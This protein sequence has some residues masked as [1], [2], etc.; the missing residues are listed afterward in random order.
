MASEFFEVLFF[1]YT[2]EY[3]VCWAWL[4]FFSAGRHFE[5]SIRPLPAIPPK[6]RKAEWKSN[7]FI[8]VFS[9]AAYHIVLN[10]SYNNI[11]MARFYLWKKSSSEMLIN[12]RVVFTFT[13]QRWSRTIFSSE[14]Q[15][16]FPHGFGSLFLLFNNTS[17][18][19]LFLST[20]LQEVLQLQHI[21]RCVMWGRNSKKLVLEI[22]VE[23][24]VSL[25]VGTG[26]SWEA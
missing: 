23:I 9:L 22:D 4:L 21:Q 18:T 7:F 12:P 14:H 19:S 13:R 24:R 26:H 6:I 25:T 16:Y 11:I 20:T 3:L 5:F 17:T 2:V 10:S 15:I 1:L 8:K